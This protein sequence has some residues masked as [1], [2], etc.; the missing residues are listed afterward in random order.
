M[1]FSSLAVNPTLLPVSFHAF[2]LVNFAEMP[3][4]LVTSCVASAQITVANGSAQLLLLWRDS[5]FSDS[6]PIKGRWYGKDSVVW[7]D[8]DSNSDTDTDSEK[9]DE[10]E[11]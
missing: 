6:L 1:F 4:R 11:V 8:S 5:R 7:M 2:S 10:N 9:D 3:R